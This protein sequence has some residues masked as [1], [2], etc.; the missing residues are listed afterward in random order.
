MSFVTDT[1]RQL[2][3]RRLWP[4]AILLAGALAAVPFLLAKEPEPVSTP[5]LPGAAATQ[6]PAADGDPV[7]AL[8]SADEER[9]RRVLGARKDPFEPAPVKKPKAE[10]P[11]GAGSEVPPMAA[12]PIDTGAGSGG[13]LPSGGGVTPP[14]VAPPAVPPVAQPPEEKKPSYPLYTL[15]VR[16]GSSESGELPTQKVRKLEALPDDEEP[17]LV[18]LGV[19]DG[20]KTA[21]FMVDAGVIAQGDGSCQP[22]PQTC[23]TLHLRAGDTEFF[24]VTDEEGNTTAQYQLDLLDIKHKTTASAAV[25]RKASKGGRKALRRLNR[26]AFKA[27]VA[28][29]K[30]AAL[31]GAGGF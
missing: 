22:D 17:L 27:E 23:E 31:A 6:A 12:P 26:K 5:P 14:V 18:Y 20:G 19:Q 11:S 24:D 28:R 15:T 10:T 8:A 21:V 1:W 13:G 3:R 16:F 29:V 9:R 25:A 4:V 7:V 30:R 2:V